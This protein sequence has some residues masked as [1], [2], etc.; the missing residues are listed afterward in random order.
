LRAVAFDRKQ[1]NHMLE[2]PDEDDDGKKEG[3]E[4]DAIRNE[5]L[6]IMRDLVNLGNQTKTAS[7]PKEPL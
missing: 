4:P 1:E 5:A 3:P 6:R 2:A 7:I